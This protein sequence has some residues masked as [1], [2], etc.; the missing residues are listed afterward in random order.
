MTEFARDDV[1]K[2]IDAFREWLKSEAA[3]KHLRTIEKE[4]QEVKDLMKKLDSM[5]K[6]SIEFTDWVLYGLLPYSKTKYAK[7]FSTFPVFMNIK[8][9]LKNYNYSDA[10]WNQI[11]NMIYGLS[12]KFQQNPEKMDKWIEEFVSDKVHT[13]MIQCGSITPIIFCI[14]DSFPLINNRVIHTYNEFSTI[15]GWND[16]MS[17][18]LEHYLDNVEKVK[19]FITA[20]EVPELNDLA[21]FDVFCYWYDY[22]Y[23]ASNP[24]DDEEAES[25]DEERIRVT[26]IDPRTFIENVPLENLAKF[27]PHSLR[28]PERIKIN[29]IISNSS[30]GKWVLPN[31]Q[32]YFDWNK[33]DVKEFLK[34]IF[35][36]YYIGALLLWDVGKEPELDTVA[37]KGVD[38][39]KEE[40]RPDS[41][42]LDG[43]QRITS[44]YYALRAPNFAL[45]GSSAPVYFYINFS[46]FFNNQNESSGI[47][48]VLPRKLGREESFKNMWFPFY[49]LEKYS[50]W[51]D[52]YEDFLLKSSSDPDKIR[53][54]R[55]IMDKKLRHIIDGFEIPYI[56]L[57]DTMELPQVT[58]IFEKINT[59]GKVL[60]VF[61][62][63]IARLSKY[64]IEL[65][66]LWEES[67][68][69]HPKLPEYY[70]SIDKMPIYILQ[71]I[72]LC[73]N[74]TSSCKR[75][76][77]LNIHQN[78][79][80]PTD[81][82]FE[83][84]WHEMAEYTN[85]AILKIENLR[86]G[87]GVKDKSVLPFAPM[88]PILA[89]LIKDVDS[90]DNKV[91]C[92]KKLAMWYWSSVFSNAYSGA[93]DAQLTA[94]FKEMKDW[95]SDDAKI[96]KTIDRAR[97]EF[98]ALN[99]LDVRSK[100]NAMYRGVLSLLALEGSNDFNTNQTLE[101]A[102]NNDRDHLFPKAEF[103]SMRNV[104]SILN[105]SW[106]SDETNRKIKRYKKPSAYVKE[107]IKEKY[108]GNEKEFLKVL[109]SHFINKNA[110]DSMTH[111]DFQGFISEREKIIL[112]KIKNAMGIVGPT[113]DHTLITPEQ[114]FSNRVAFW[115]AIKSCDGYI[116][117]ID[118]YFSKEGLELLSQSLD[119]NRTKTVKILISIEKADEKFRS[120]FK[121]FRDELKNKNVICELR[122]ITD[123][124]LKS[125]IHDR[126]ILSKNNCYNIPSADT[127]ARGQYSE[128]KATENKPPFEDW[129][130][131]SLDIINDWNEIQK[132]RK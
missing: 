100:S 49:E 55:R 77:I 75:E 76:D 31:F 125:S 9:F 65:K 11:A 45:R 112:D 56:S 70:K 2:I 58:D 126:W 40:I 111:D 103:H 81:L 23:K 20:L 64:Q 53:S 115:N 110:Y 127:V 114:P 28:N 4:K 33:N 22:F 109:E 41:I 108:G 82:S 24:S 46:E 79:F 60:S 94:D 25:E 38:I 132:S 36:D 14:N 74:R 8:L 67:V 104:N 6:T 57:P 52:G 113:H 128:I 120:V 119:T 32:R 97:R 106:M 123:S 39:K 19:K 130:T 68:K 34:S 54:I 72:S 37:I 16:T 87:F 50:E 48:E 83:E 78:V 92:Y 73:Y 35:N 71:A 27:E 18:K 85:K 96:P 118:K 44:L 29:Q 116:Y 69:R 66:K 124:K 95:F 21:V 107:F 12:K 129:W 47:I 84:T 3:Q 7:R 98:I 101:N 61:D 91:D 42:I 99:L 13:R 93:V 102:R 5:D 105:M 43:Q 117:W 88:V 80:E 63:L 90:R 15:F 10:E 51:V 86:D 62:L 121:D 1:Q 59:M 17:Q 30:K 122:V 89:A 131:K 26:E